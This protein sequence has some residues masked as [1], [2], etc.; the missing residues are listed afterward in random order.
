[1]VPDS[2]FDVRS[3]L[4]DL[5]F[6]WR[7]Q[8]AHNVN[9]LA[10]KS[11]REFL[12]RALSFDSSYKH[13]VLLSFDVFKTEPGD[14]KKIVERKVHL[15]ALLN[16]EK[17]EM[18]LQAPENLRNFTKESFVALLEIA[19]EVGCERVYI[20]LEK[21]HSDFSTLS[22]SFMY[23]DF[24]PVNPNIRQFDNCMLLGCEL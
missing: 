8:S 24:R 4:L 6:Q 13:S 15:L 20:A 17:K 1:M 22:K 9:L 3:T 18:L 7:P 14:T 16:P 5:D 2:V 12:S 23:F 10:K 21:A 19:E 11:S